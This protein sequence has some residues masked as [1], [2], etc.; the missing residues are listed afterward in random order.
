M[1]PD[2]EPTDVGASVLGSL[3]AT[4]PTGGGLIHLLYP[5]PGRRLLPA[6]AR[7]EQ[8]LRR[9]S[10]QAGTMPVRPAAPK[11]NVTRFTPISKLIAGQRRS[12]PGTA[13]RHRNGASRPMKGADKTVAYEESP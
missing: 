6:E 11:K 3:L 13:T 4:A 9:A 12:L 2:R 10:G 5:V 7:G 8:N 1:A